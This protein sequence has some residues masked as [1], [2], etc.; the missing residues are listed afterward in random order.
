MPTTRSSAPWAAAA[1]RLGCVVAL[2][3]IAA[4]C[5][6]NTYKP[7]IDRFGTATQQAREAYTKME[8]T[9]LAAHAEDLRQQML[10]GD[11]RAT[12]KPGTC[13]VR[14]ERC[15]IMVVDRSGKSQPLHDQFD[16]INALMGDIADYAAN[17]RAIVAS[18]APQQVTASV[19]AAAG[20]I[21]AL[22]ANIAKIKGAGADKNAAFIEPAANI[23]G[24]AVGEFV[25]LLQVDALRKATARANPVIQE[26]L[27]ILQESAIAASSVANAGFAKRVADLREAYRRAPGDRAALDRFEKEVRDFDTALRATSPAVFDAMATAHGDLTDA[28]AGKNVSVADAYAAIEQFAAKAEA[29]YK[30]IAALEAAAK[31]SKKQNTR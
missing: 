5:S 28:L 16:N 15:E 30:L 27:P 7:A 12:L 13:N 23:I 10:R 22:S 6:V 20:S 18:D 8:A 3:L 17:L 31:A 14:S 9:V 1:Q 25:N 26:A 21:K 2:G 19:G 4:G 29:L 24:W 11:L